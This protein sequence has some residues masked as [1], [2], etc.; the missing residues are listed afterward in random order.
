MALERSGIHVLKCLKNARGGEMS[1][2][3]LFSKN[4]IACSRHVGKLENLFFLQ[5]LQFRIYSGI[6]SR[7]FQ[8]FHADFNISG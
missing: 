6:S 4:D 1:M 7:F 2:Y 5:A 3:Q 8:W